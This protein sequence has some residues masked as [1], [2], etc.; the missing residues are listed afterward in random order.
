MTELVIAIGI[1]LWAA[2]LYIVFLEPLG[3]D[4]LWRWQRR[5]TAQGIE[6]HGR[7]RL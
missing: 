7:K 1:C 4:L 5:H 2:F 3:R 6:L